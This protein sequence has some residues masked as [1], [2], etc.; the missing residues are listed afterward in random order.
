MCHPDGDISF[1]NDAAHGVAPHPDDIR[2]YA[3]ALGCRPAAALAGGLAW[4]H[5]TATGYIV[6]QMAAGA[7]ALLDV[8]EVGPS[9]QPGHAHADTLSFELSLF[10]QRVLVNSG[11]SRYGEDD[12]RHRQRSTAAH[13]TV[14]IDGES[15][16]EVWSGFRV[17]RRARPTVPVVRRDDSGLGPRLLVRCA[18]D[19][20]RRLPGAPVHQREWVFEPGRLRVTDRLSGTYRKAVGRFHLHPDIRVTSDRELLLGGGH[21]VRWNVAG[22]QARVVPASWHPQFGA[23]APTSCI[24]VLFG[25]SEVTVDFIWE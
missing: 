24:E 2:A 8:A 22:G 14:E 11:T 15:S 12:E 3:V 9:Y 18:H 5:L 21:K 16:S 7:R 6:V 20:Y 13:N 17:A 4:S 23:S 10:G 19:G 1:F 25:G